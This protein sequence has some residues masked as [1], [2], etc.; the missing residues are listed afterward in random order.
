MLEPN[1][2]WSDDMIEAL[3]DGVLAGKSSTIIASELSSKYGKMFSRNSVIG[4]AHRLGLS[5]VAHPSVK[6]KVDPAKRDSKPKKKVPL[7]RINSKP[8]KEVA[9]SNGFSNPASKAVNFFDLRDG[10]CKFAIGDSKKKT[11]RFCGAPA[12]SEK[13]RTY[14]K[15]CY[16]I[17]YVPA[18]FPVKISKSLR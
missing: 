7:I 13:N 12:N 5:T 17:A 6:I 1:K 14:C 8:E 10:M 18:K 9:I 3:K 4:K 15:H 11:L 16:G 2:V